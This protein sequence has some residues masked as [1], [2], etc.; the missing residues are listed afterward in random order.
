VLAAGVLLGGG[1]GA[2]AQ[3]AADVT[4]R[5][6]APTGPHRIGITTLYLVD[7]SRPDPW[8]PEIPVR[9][10]MATVL[11]PARTVLG[12][13]LAPQMSTGAAAAFALIAPLGHPQLPA[14][15]V[16]WAATMTHSHLGAPAQ[17]IARPVLLYSP[18]G[19]DP[20]TLGT[21]LAEELASRGCVV[22]MID[23][24]G[25]A[26]AVEFPNTA[27]YRGKVRETVFRADPWTEPTIYRTMIG[28]RVED[29][30]FVLDQLESLAAGHNPDALG[31]ALPQD[32]RRALDLRRVGM[33]GHSAG[34]STAA[35]TMYQDRR[36]GVAINLEGYLDYPADRPGHRGRLLPVAEHGVDRP[37][38]LLGSDG[39]RNEDIVRSWSAM[40]AHPGARTRW[41]QID[42]AAH[43]VFTDYAA[44]VPELQ[45]D[46]LM[47]TGGR[48]EMIGAIDPATSVPLVRDDVHSFFIRHLPSL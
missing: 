17:A 33:Y 6:P 4:V 25:D 48:T 36:I 18:G 37:L 14:A 26:S 30:R 45:A 24:P 10:V 7:R 8:N 41:R 16:D 1:R 35:E 42:D 11:Y 27:K 3:A 22:V 5:L 39:F 31:R 2:L 21:G 28:T 40:L 29:A 12:H 13:P 19:G 44:I 32:L 38:L 15:G 9:E 47:T 46:G 23:H 43:W 34:G 20:R